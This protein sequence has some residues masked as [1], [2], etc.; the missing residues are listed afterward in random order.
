MIKNG[1]ILS[2]DGL[3]I[4]LL[5]YDGDMIRALIQNKITEDKIVTTPSHTGRVISQASFL[6]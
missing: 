3:Y 1:A 4:L 2:P 5:L 6:R